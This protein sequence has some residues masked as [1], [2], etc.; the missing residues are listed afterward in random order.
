NVITGYTQMLEEGACGPL[1]AEQADVLARVKRSAFDQLALVEDLLD[2]SAMQARDLRLEL[3]PVALGELFAE[4]EETVV[5]L[6]RGRPIRFASEVGTDA[7]VVEADRRRLKQLL[8][9]LLA[10]AIR[11]TA[12]GTIRLT[13]ERAGDRVAIRVVDTGSGIDPA[14]LERIFRPF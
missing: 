14:D 11:F 2:L 5:P 12:D 10:N 3:G 6:L 7:R 9:N 1:C 13:A 8:T 4:L